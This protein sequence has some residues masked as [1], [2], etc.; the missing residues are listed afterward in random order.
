MPTLTRTRVSVDLAAGHTGPDCRNMAI[1]LERQLSNGYTRFTSA[2][3][4]PDNPDVYLAEHR[5]V[6]KRAAHAKRLGYRFATIDRH[7]HED[8]VYEINVSMPERQGRPMSPGYLQRPVFGENPCRCDRHHVYTYGVLRHD[9]LVAYLWLYRAGELA[10]ISSILGHAA[11]LEHDVM[12]LLVADA[13]SDQA[14]FG[15]TLFYNL[16]SSGTDGLRFF[17]ERIGLSPTDIEWL[18]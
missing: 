1:D 14:R 15:G 6:R 9:T 13:I 2:M 7:Q 4:M 5:T 16:H 12:Y 8:A 10:M 17:K 18:L 11:A 3:P